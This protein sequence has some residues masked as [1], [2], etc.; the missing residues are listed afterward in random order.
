MAGLKALPKDPLAKDFSA[1]GETITAGTGHELVESRVAGE[2][3][4]DVGGECGVREAA[5]LQD[6]W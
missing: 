1:K 5:G 3:V 2:C 4:R 6:E